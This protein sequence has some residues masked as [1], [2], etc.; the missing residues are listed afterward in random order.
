MRAHNRKHQRQCNPRFKIRLYI[1][2]ITSCNILYWHELKRWTR[3]P[4]A[5]INR[6]N[7]FWDVGNA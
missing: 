7:Q 1:I 2:C 4:A 3:V 5:Q 6:V